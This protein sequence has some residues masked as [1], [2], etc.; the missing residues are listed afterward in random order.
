MST[1]AR[2]PQWPLLSIIAGWF[3]HLW[4]CKSIIYKKRL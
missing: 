2:K 1:I 3:V 4:R